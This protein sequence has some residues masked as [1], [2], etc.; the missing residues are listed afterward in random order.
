MSRQYGN[1]Y[2]SFYMFFKGYSS[3]RNE[4]E[5][6]IKKNGKLTEEQ[7]VKWL[8]VVSNE[9]MSSEE[10]GE[11]DTLLVHPIPWRSQYVDQMFK[12]I[13]AFCTNKRSPQARRQMKQR[14]VGSPSSRQCPIDSAPEW[15]VAIDTN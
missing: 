1:Y 7:R 5:S 6:A 11:D 2:F 12:K 3:E 4:R 14:S 15:A 10:S 8:K 9:Y 13:D